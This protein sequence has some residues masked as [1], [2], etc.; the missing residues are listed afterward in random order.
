[1]SDTRDEFSLIDRIRRRANV[2]S[3]LGLG[4]GDDTAHLLTN[5]DDGVL[6]AVDVL[7]EGVH[8]DLSR[9]SPDLVGRKALAVNLSDI[10]AMAG[11]PTAAVVGLVLPR[12]RG[13]SLGESMMEGLIS[14]ADEFD[15]AV[16]GGDT[17]SW[18]GPLVISVTILGEPTGKGPV[19]RAGAEPGDWMFVTG[20]LGGSLVGRH[21]SFTPRIVEAIALHQAVDLHAMID[22]SDGLASDLRHIA[23]ESQVGATISADRIPIH[24]DVDA[25]LP[26]DDRLRHALSDGEDFELLLAVSPLDG[27][28]LLGDPPIELPLTH[29]GEVTDEIECRIRRPDGDVEPLPKGG[30]HHGFSE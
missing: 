8:F 12:D 9:T 17:N 23:N 20:A 30:W 28:R 16:I 10:A 14:L 4:I 3:L 22:I 2:T 6:V 21:L 1:M 26:V 25:S 24:E 11:Q 18:N 29:I 15:V 27:E 5:R 19:T 7:T 13:A